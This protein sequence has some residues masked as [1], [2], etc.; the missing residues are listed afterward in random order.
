[1]PFGLPFSPALPKGYR[2]PSDVK[3]YHIHEAGPPPAVT[4]PKSD[5]GQT[6]TA[7]PWIERGRSAQQHVEGRCLEAQAHEIHA[8][9]DQDK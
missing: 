9:R 8:G 5:L 7:V 3:D 1:V 2:Q 4:R 6:E